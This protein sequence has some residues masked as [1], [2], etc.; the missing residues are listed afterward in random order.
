M[1]CQ[2]LARCGMLCSRLQLD[3]LHT[4]TND[5]LHLLI[6][7]CFMETMKGHLQGMDFE[8]GADV[9]SKN[10]ELDLAQT[11]FLLS[12]TKKLPT[13]P[14]VT[15]AK[16]NKLSVFPEAQRM[17]P[18]PPYDEGSSPLPIVPK[19]GKRRRGKGRKAGT[20]SPRPFQLPDGKGKVMISQSASDSPACLPPV[21]Q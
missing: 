3:F 13:D 16:R 1:H 4:K 12:V 8:P 20:A 11:S 21:S 18:A 14:A 10:S 2:S 6:R 9:G 7:Q 17:K 19:R 15:D 5:A